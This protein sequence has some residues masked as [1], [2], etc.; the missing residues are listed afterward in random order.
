MFGHLFC[1]HCKMFIFARR[2][3]SLERANI[4]IW[5]EKVPDSFC[6]IMIFK[7]NIFNKNR[8]YENK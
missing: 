2:L 5:N 4:G 8:Y 3:C 6:G 1:D 7:S